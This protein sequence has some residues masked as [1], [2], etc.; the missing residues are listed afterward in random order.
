M[1]SLCTT[2]QGGT[3][4]NWWAGGAQSG[5]QGGNPIWLTGVPPSSKQGWLPSSQ[6]GDTPIQL[7]GVP[8]SSWQ[9]VSPSSQWG[10]P[11]PPHL[12]NMGGTPSGWQRVPPARLGWGT[13]LCRQDGGTPILTRWGYFHHQDGVPPVRTGWRYP[14]PPNW[15]NVG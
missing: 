14:T 9:G 3:P 13:P 1:F 11:T 8:L 7:M 12:A 4:T 15:L 6:Q 2:W 10:V 5:Q